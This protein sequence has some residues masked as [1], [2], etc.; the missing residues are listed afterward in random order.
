MEEENV[1][2][3]KNNA[4]IIWEK[5]FVKFTQLTA[6]GCKYSALTSDRPGIVVQLIKEMDWRRTEGQRTAI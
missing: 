2:E 3:R 5:H 1:Q 6:I 4:P